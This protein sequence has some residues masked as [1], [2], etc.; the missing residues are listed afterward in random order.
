MTILNPF[1]GREFA[2]RTRCSLF[3]SQRMLP[4]AQEYDFA[5]WLLKSKAPTRRQNRWT[6]G[7]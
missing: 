1:G 6:Y 3:A 5:I 7:Q 2:S 4:R